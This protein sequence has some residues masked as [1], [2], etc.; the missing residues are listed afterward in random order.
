M[1]GGSLVS[2]CTNVCTKRVDFCRVKN[3]FDDV[4]KVVDE[5]CERNRRKIQPKEYSFD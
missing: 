2:P 3:S 1:A 5:D 4:T